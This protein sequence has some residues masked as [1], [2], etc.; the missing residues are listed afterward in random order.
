MTSTGILGLTGSGKTSNVGHHLAH[1][2]LSSGAGGL[3]LTVKPEETDRW[4]R[5]AEEA[6]REDDVIRFSADSGHTFDFMHYM[7][8]R[9]GRGAGML[10]SVLD[11]LS[12]ALEIG[13]PQG[14]NVSAE[15][16]FEG[17]SEQL[18]R[19]AIAALRLAGHSVSIVSMANFI[20]SLPLHPNHV[21][22][23]QPTNA[24]FYAEILAAIR[25]RQSSFTQ[26]QW[27]DCAT[28][29]YFCGHDWPNMDPR[30]RSNIHAT[31][32]AMA[33]R[34]MYEPLRSIFCSG[35][36]SVIPE[37]ITQAGKILIIDFSVHEYGTTGQ[38]INGIWKLVSEAA[39]LRRDVEA[40][41]GTL[42][43]VWQD[44]VQRLILPRG[45]DAQFSQTCRSALI[46]NVFITQSVMNLAE[47]F[48]EHH[49][50]PKT[51]SWLAN[52]GNLI[53]CANTCADTNLFASDLVGRDYMH[54]RSSGIGA[55][56]PHVGTQEHLDHIVIPRTFSRLRRPSADQPVAE[57]IVVKGGET[58]EETRTQKNPEGDAF[59]RAGFHRDIYGG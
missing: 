2:L 19:N 50:G 16:F 4:L 46:A 34:F 43:F 7:M 3:V 44:E 13:K 9:P 51:K 30:T 48:G 20:D 57:A 21:Q 37:M 5:Y 53:F 14:Q 33:C 32:N 26:A 54:L 52:T 49:L 22:A 36:S 58:F 27:N 31:W 41:G 28:A 15:K 6:G 12:T 29:L 35:H 45:K 23:P 25:E 17:A 56:A 39:W 42:G 1:A 55:G 10:D 8:N 59:L 38:L 24:S 47:T 40:E 11:M 18:M